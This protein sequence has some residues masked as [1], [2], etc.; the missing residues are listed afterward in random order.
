MPALLCDFVQEYVVP[1]DVTAVRIETDSSG[2]DSHS[3]SSLTLQVRPGA[4]LRVRYACSP[5]QPSS[6]ATTSAP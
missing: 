5:A 4:T 6:A 1:P 3:S 2:P